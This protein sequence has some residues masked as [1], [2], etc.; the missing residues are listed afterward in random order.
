MLEGGFSAAYT[1]LEGKPQPKICAAKVAEL[2]AAA[3]KAAADAIKAANAD[4]ESPEAATAAMAA[5]AAERDVTRARAELV[6]AQ[7]G[8]N[9]QDLIGGED[10]TS[11][12]KKKVGCLKS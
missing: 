11:K 9:L 3:Q 2:E 12:K 4:E 10:V 6:A 1:Y 7:A 5:V 8:P